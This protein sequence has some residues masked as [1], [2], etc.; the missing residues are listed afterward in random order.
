[1]SEIEN[2]T[3][4]SADDEISLIDLV[5][6]LIRHRMMIIIGTVLAFVLGAVYLFVYPA[7]FPKA[8][9]RE[10]TVEYSINVASIP[11]AI[12]SKLPAKFS[13]LKNV[14]NA[15][16][17]DPVFLVKEMKKNN[18]Y[19]AE[20]SKPLNDLELN[21]FVQTLLKDKKLSSKSASIRDEIV[22]TM[23]IPEEGLD[24]ATRMIDSMI[25][26]INE[27][28]ERPFLLEVDKLKKTQQ[29][30]Y[31]EIVKVYS[32]NANIADAQSLMLNVRQIE[33][34][35]NDY[36]IVAFREVEPFVV[37]EPLGRIKKLI[38]VTFA[39]FF[40]L[41]FAAF[42]NNAIYNI[43]KDPEASSKLKAA[44]DNGKLGK[45]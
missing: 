25:A 26:T 22:V 7:L 8:V 2:Y 12:A 30:T 13:N 28:V 9:K 24:T 17:N 16:V 15:E 19:A 3:A 33:E 42:L 34:F 6:V 37:L 27:N 5:S 39:A 11:G 1:M 4:N 35:L 45:K 32:E 14:V 43:K 41:I 10:I 23:T 18:P 29:D 21:K 40:I 20:D 31:D 36:K 38:I 44:W